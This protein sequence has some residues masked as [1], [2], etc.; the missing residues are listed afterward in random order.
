[1][2]QQQD[3]GAAQSIANFFGKGK[4]KETKT[5]EKV[6]TAWHDAMVK[7]AN[8]SFAKGY[9]VANATPQSQ[10]SSAKTKTRKRVARKK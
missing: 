1:M 3:Y 5:P 4:K 2:A 9:K 8:E 7:R 6:D 10:K